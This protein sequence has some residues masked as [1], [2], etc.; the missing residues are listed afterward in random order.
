M[1]RIVQ[2][3]SGHSFVVSLRFKKKK[4]L[5][6]NLGVYESLH[7][8][9]MKKNILQK[10]LVPMFSMDTYLEDTGISAIY[11]TDGQLTYK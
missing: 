11:Y 4:D 3:I 7:E 6:L 1:T 2:S 5:S 9:I 8:A 10:K